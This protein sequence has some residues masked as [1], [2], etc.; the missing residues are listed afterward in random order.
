[1]IPYTDMLRVVEDGVEVD[2]VPVRIASVMALKVLFTYTAV[3]TT[4]FQSD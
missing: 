3:Q 2:E 4:D 1:M